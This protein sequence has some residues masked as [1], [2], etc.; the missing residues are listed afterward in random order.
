ML[1]YS[2][3]QL[4]CV[5]I[6]CNLWSLFDIFACENFRAKDVNAKL[7]KMFTP[8]KCPLNSSVRITFNLIPNY[9]KGHTHFI[10]YNLSAVKDSFILRIQLLWVISRCKSISV[11]ATNYRIWEG[12][13]DILRSLAMWPCD[14]VISLCEITLGVVRT[15]R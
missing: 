8:R 15:L 2:R 12:D 13:T 10:C 14:N 7:V 3:C 1:E 4:F 5:Y 6:V 11:M 9:R